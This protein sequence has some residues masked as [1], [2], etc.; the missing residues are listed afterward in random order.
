M[1]DDNWK[2]VTVLLLALLFT[3]LYVESHVNNDFKMVKLI[4]KQKNEIE[5]LKSYIKVLERGNSGKWK[6]CS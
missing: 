4:G 6:R 2:R 3:C 5:F 1:N